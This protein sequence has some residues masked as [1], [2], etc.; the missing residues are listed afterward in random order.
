MTEIE[1][2][3]DLTDIPKNEWREKYIGDGYRYCCYRT[4][5]DDSISPEDRRHLDWKRGEGS[6]GQIVLFGYDKANNPC[7]FICPWKSHIAYNVGYDTKKRDIFGRYVAYKYFNN[8]KQR[9]NYIKNAEG[10]SIVE[11]FPPQSEFLHEMFDSVALDPNFNKQKMR[12]HYFD[13]ETEIS[14]SFE[15]PKTARNRINMMTIYD[16]ETEKYY[17]WSLQKCEKK[18]DDEYDEN[19]NLVN[20]SPIKDL[21]KDKFVLFDEFY[22]NEGRM[23]THFIG[24]FQNNYP[25]ALCAHNGQAFDFPYLVNRIERVLGNPENVDGF[26]T[27]DFNKLSDTTKRLS[28]VGR[29]SIRKNNL[30]DERANKQAEIMADIDGI[31]LVDTLV[32]YRDKY[33]I[34]QPLDGGNGLDNI[35]EVEL[36]AH[37][38]HYDGTLKELYENNWNKFYFYNLIDVDLLRRVEEKVKMIPLSRLIASSGLSNYDAIY[39]SIGYLIGSLSMFSNTQM[40]TVFTSFKTK[41]EDSIPYEGAFVFPPTQGIYRGGI[42]T[43]DFNSLYPS[44]IRAGNFSIETYVG[45]ISRYPIDDPK[46]EFFAKEPPIDIYGNDMTKGKF[47]TEG[48]MKYNAQYGIKMRNKTEDSAI[49][50][51]YFLSARGGAQKIMTRKQLDKLLEEKCIFTRNNTLFLKHSV[52]QGVISA[53]CKHFYGLRKSTK[54]TM[55][56]LKMDIY[57][58]KVEESKIPETKALIENLNARQQ[59][60]KIMLNSIYGCLSTPFSPIY[61]A[62]IAQ[63][64]TRT[65]RWCNTS[66]CEFIRKRFKELFGIDD[67]YTIVSSGDTDSFIETSKIRIKR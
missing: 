48:E 67:N 49:E 42:A 47:I 58:K 52:K 22:N 35:G 34:N 64:I 56:K 55:E 1:N 44:S 65:G 29:V 41:K 23:L 45:K 14:K 31:F 32:L 30:D 57:N 6:L 37:K 53:W 51:F 19:G 4:V 9:K 61:N 66:S 18:F 50:K 62:Y 21:P 15:Y 63:S 12:I 27:A 54:K 10:L 25:D 33:K 7:T 3:I 24:W 16:T 17:T 28:P 5:V 20:E 60:I 46:M 43:V 36:G 38:I 8:S 13:I 26:D 59:A 11:C 40:K 39:S 2:C